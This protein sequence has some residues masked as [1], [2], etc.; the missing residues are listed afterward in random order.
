MSLNILTVGLCLLAS[1]PLACIAR[2]PD[3]TKIQSISVNTLVR[4]H[5]ENWLD[6]S[7]GNPIADPLGV[8]QLVIFGDSL[9]DT[10]NLHR[11][12][13][14]V[15]LP[16]QIF[17]QSRFSNGPIWADYIQAPLKGWTIRNYAAGGAK[18]DDYKLIARFFVPSLQQQV[19]EFLKDKSK[20]GLN[21]TL[22]VIWIGPNNYVMDGEQLQDPKGNPDR[23]KLDPFVSSVIRDIQEAVTR[24]RTAGYTRFLLGSMP[25][26]GVIN[27]NPVEPIKVGRPTLFA[28]TASHNKALAE[29]LHQYKSMS[30]IRVDTFHAGELNQATIDHP[31]H[32]GFTKLDQP[33]YVGSLRGKF[34]GE[35]AFCNDPSG[36]KFWEYMHPNTKMHCY[37]A[38]QFLQ[39]LQDAGYVSGFSFEKSIERCKN[40]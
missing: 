36:Y 39:D 26:L 35:K 24:L 40:L 1:L 8:H 30:S 22:V 10:G 23:T 19:S 12:T 14:G 5:Q 37:Y 17:Y 33:C 13:F 31:Q 25:E 16:P 32:W 38:G 27:I 29:I 21:S 9:S 4:E 11:R 18:T 3:G 15:M 34:Y 6:E 28:A 7:V 2:N 20:T